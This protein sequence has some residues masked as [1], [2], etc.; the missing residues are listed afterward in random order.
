MS[1]H[2]R[3][4]FVYGEHH[5]PARIQADWDRLFAAQPGLQLSLS[6]SPYASFIDPLVSMVQQVEL[7]EPDQRLTVMMP[8]VIGNRWFDRYLLNQSIDVVSSALADG[9]SRLFTRYR[10]YLPV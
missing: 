7:E 2:V 6:P 10:H 5:D 3:V 4:L 8:E 1:R 9:R